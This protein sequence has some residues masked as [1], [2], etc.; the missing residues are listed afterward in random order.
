LKSRGACEF[1]HHFHFERGAAGLRHSRG[2]AAGEKI[3]KIILQFLAA[4]LKTLR[5]KVFQRRRSFFEQVPLGRF[6]SS[7][8]RFRIRS[9]IVSE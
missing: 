7:R 3:S 5:L 9:E 6:Y 8:P 1:A 4:M 2:P